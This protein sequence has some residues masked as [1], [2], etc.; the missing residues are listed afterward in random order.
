MPT[1]FQQ[2]PNQLNPGFFRVTLDLTGYPTADADNNG[3][4]TPNSSDSF[5]TAELPTTLALGKRRARGNMRFRN[6]INRLSNLSDCQILDVEINETG[7]GADGDTQATKLVFTVKYDRPAWILGTVQQML[8]SPYTGYDGA[9]PV[10]T[11]LLALKDQ[12]ARGIG[13]ATTAAMKVYDGTAKEDRQL[14]ITVAAPGVAG[15]LWADVTVALVEG[16][17]VISTDNDVV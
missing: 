9:T 12:I 13:D 11:T 4:V 14:A 5:A 2:D 6:I 17:E 15:D 10:T 7:G 3:G 1:G 16:T 8:S